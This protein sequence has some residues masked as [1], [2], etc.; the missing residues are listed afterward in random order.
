MTRISW[1]N[2]AFPGRWG[3]R[4]ME[5]GFVEWERFDLFP[6]VHGL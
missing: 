2:S 6:E 1:S 4:M 5:K 3:W